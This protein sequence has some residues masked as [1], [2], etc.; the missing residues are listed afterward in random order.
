MEENQTLEIETNPSED[1][2]LDEQ[3]D[4]KREIVDFVKLVVWF[5]VIFLGLKFAVVEGYE[6]QG[7]S[8]LPNLQTNDRIL[9]LKLPHQLSKL[10]FLNRLT[11]FDSGD[12]IVFD[13][14]DVSNKRYVK[15]V[16]ALGPK[17]K[18]NTAEAQDSSDSN[19]VRVEFNYGNVYV[20][21]RIVEEEY[22][23][24]DNRQISEEHQLILGPDEFYVLGD[25]RRVSK[26]SRS[27]DAIQDK[28]IIGKA[29]FR[30]WPINRI[31]LIH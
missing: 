16:I 11:P 8:M 23:S 2:T 22:L 21:N 26:D 17:A 27:F 12:V 18:P 28:A 6:V 15:R 14:P 31:S 9:V 7:D 30:F 25:N 24:E 3:H 5:L 4:L 29:I 1:S 10:P 20:N 13:S 19:G